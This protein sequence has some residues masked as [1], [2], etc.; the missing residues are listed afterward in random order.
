MSL[1]LDVG[2]IVD[3]DTE[4]QLLVSASGT[5]YSLRFAEGLSV[6]FDTAEDL[7]R[8]CAVIDAALDDAALNEETS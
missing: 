3:S 2:A 8:M 5:A 4:I 7:H 1:Y 6:Q